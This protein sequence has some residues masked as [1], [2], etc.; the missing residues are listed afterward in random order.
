MILKKTSGPSLASKRISMKKITT[1]NGEKL[2]VFPTTPRLETKI[3]DHS[4]Y[5]FY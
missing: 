1:G 3:S 2:D 5:T 4:S